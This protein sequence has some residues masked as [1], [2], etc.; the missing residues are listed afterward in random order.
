[1]LNEVNFSL[2]YIPL[3]LKSW[4]EDKNTKANSIWTSKTMMWMV[5]V[6][7]HSQ[8]CRWLLRKCCISALTITLYLS[9]HPV[10][11]FLD[12]IHCSWVTKKLVYVGKY[13]WKNINQLNKIGST[14]ST[15]WVIQY[16]LQKIGQ[17]ALLKIS[18][19]VPM[20]LHRNMWAVHKKRSKNVCVKNKT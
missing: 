16:H 12:A 4:T 15:P 1:M 5:N 10:Q 13:R 3:W 2:T 11:S 20:S 9:S 19:Y 8:W 7:S 17:S 14:M 18:M 6:T